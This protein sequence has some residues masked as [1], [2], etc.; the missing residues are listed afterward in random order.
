[1]LTFELPQPYTPV[2][3]GVSKIKGRNLGYLKSEIEADRTVSKAGNTTSHVKQRHTLDYTQC[4][5]I[6][7]QTLSSS[8]P[9]L[10]TKTSL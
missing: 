9:Y 4:K 5:T 10:K 7:S 6:Q 1:M 3:G 2:F 8:I